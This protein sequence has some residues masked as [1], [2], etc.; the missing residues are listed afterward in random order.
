MNQLQLN[1]FA[2]EVLVPSY[3][4]TQNY[5]IDFRDEHDFPPTVMAKVHHMRSIAQILVMKSGRFELF[6]EF[7]DHGRL[8]YLDRATDR[9]YLLRSMGTVSIEEG[10]RQRESLFDASQMI[11]SDIVMLI[12]KYGREGLELSVAGTRRVQNRSRLEPSGSPTFVGTW[13]YFDGGTPPFDQGR[14][15][16]FSDVGEMN[17]FGEGIAQ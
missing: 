7:L 13:S 1:M 15:D 11:A 14:T 6:T 4:E 9:V 5:V 16:P 12:Y 10:K 8:Q 17:E 2:T 3:L